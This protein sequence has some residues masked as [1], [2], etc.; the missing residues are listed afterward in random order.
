MSFENHPSARASFSLA[1]PIAIEPG[2]VIWSYDFNTWPAILDLSKFSYWSSTGIDGG[3]GAEWNR[4]SAGAG[5]QQVGN[6]TGLIVGRTYTLKLFVKGNTAG[7]SFGM[8]VAGASSSSAVT[9]SY[10]QRARTFVAT[11]TAAPLFFISGGAEKF[12][13]DNI[14]LELAPVLGTTAQ[15]PISEGDLTL[16]KGVAPYG[17]AQVTVPLMNED[18]LEQLDP[19]TNQQVQVTASATGRWGLTD[20]VYSAWTIQ[21]R[22]RFANPRANS[23]LRFSNSG[24]AAALSNITDFPGDVATALRV[25]R[26]ATTNTRWLDMVTQTEIPASTQVRLTAIVRSSVAMTSQTFSYRPSGPASTTGQVT[27]TGQTIPAGVS[28]LVMNVTTS[29][30]APASNAA[31]SITGAGAVSA[32]FDI[33]KIIVEVGPTYG[34]YLDGSLTSTDPLEG[35]GWTGSAN[36]ST[37]FYRT[38]TLV[39][40][41]Q[42]VWIEEDSRPFNLVLR[43]RRVNHADKTVALDLATDEAIL[44][45]YAPLVDD[46]TAVALQNSLRSIVNYVLDKASPG[47]ALQPGGPDVPFKVLSDAT[48]LFLDPRYARSGAGGYT[49]GNVALITDTTWVGAENLW[50]VH[51][52]GPTT[53]DGYVDM[54]NNAGLAY[55]VAVGKTY[56]YSA[57]GSV[58]TTMGGTENTARSRRLVVIA[59]VNGAYQDLAVSPKVPNVAETGASAGTR[60]SVE[61]T[62]PPGT[63]ELWFRAYHGHTSGTITWRQFR[64]SEKEEPSGPHNV[65]YFDGAR[66]NTSEY[67][68]SW[69]D[70]ADASVSRRVALIDRAPELL[71]WNAGDDAWSF[72]EPLMTSSKL[73]LW[74]DEQRRWWLIDPAEYEVPGRII[75]QVSN[76]VDG[77]DTIDADDGPQLDGAIARFTWRDF[78]GDTQTKDDFFGSPG[79]VRV[80]EF[81]RPYPGPGTA[82]A[83]MRR[84]VGQKRTQEV[85]VP[86]DYRVTPGQEISISLPGTVDQLGRLQSVHWQLA[87]G[88]MDLGASGITEVT[89]GSWLA[90][91]P[92]QDWNE[93][94][95][96]Q[97]WA[98][99]T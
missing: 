90:R 65:E 38:R 69:Q 28:T 87:E 86:S 51:L 12:Y 95:D 14:S 63:T 84:Y 6:I 50:G 27:L 57:T 58:R 72:L 53:N 1:N 41:P 77:T 62:V 35:W 94:P 26:S 15:L 97:T 40:P 45:T 55:G 47:A 92:E 20:P 64:L 67:G 39:T 82:A 56:V 3:P 48:N 79:R 93:V 5:T 89:P 96:T 85:T 76:T 99:L 59:M 42:R 78:N 66:T 80:F 73:K 88:V 49:A 2:G 19:Y 30:T 70:A 43:N 68:H 46:L 81:D 32:T 23:Q 44:M 74:A 34:D 11:S 29:T 61:F 13:I 75:A 36:V 33:T 71:L 54:K 22:N 18:L 17:Q 98:S 31:F 10:V 24:T 25:T 9:A 52:S 60:V 37:S 8:Q 91:D 7:I 4:S 21:R 16:D 83:I